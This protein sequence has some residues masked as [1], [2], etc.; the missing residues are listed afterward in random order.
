M[1]LSYHGVRATGLPMA[2]FLSGFPLRPGCRLLRRRLLGLLALDRH[3]HLLLPGRRLARLLG[4]LGR[5]RRHGLLT[6]A[7]PQRL[8][9]IDDVLSLGTLLRADRLAGALLV[10]EVYQ[11]GLVVILK[12]LRLESAGLLLLQ[13]R[14]TSVANGA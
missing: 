7:P 11:R 12:L 10:D 8:H 2:Q 3:Q 6:H 9:Q 5:F 14:A 1:R 13:R 4:G